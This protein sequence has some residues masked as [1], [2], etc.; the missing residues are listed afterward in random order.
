MLKAEGVSK[1]YGDHRA[2][3][4]FNVE[5]EQG[6]VFGLLGPNG[7]GKT[8]FIRILNQITAPDQGSIR[9][10]GEKLQAKHIQEIGYLPEER[11]L[12]P[13][14]KVGEQLLYLARLKG[15]SK[16]EANRKVKDWLERFELM[17]RAKKNVEELSKGLAQKVQFIASVIHEPS[18]IILDEPFTGF[19]PINTEQIK[20]E[21]LRLRKDGATV[22]FST[23]RMESVE[24]LCEKIVLINKG[25]KVLDGMLS[26]IKKQ[27]RSGNYIIRTEQA[28]G[29]ISGLNIIEH[30]QH[31]DAHQY[32]IEAN[33]LNKQSLL[34]KVLPAGLVSFE[35]EEAHLHDIFIKLARS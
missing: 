9:L 34:E 32:L 31:F 20:Q 29:T 35:E 18:L 19:D 14:M 10:N 27:Y 26:D 25:E 21:I 5:I 13:K 1:Y 3:H 7:A 23:H 11:G 22:I 17:D 33:A 12:Y 24:E 15:L 28:L 2:L 6:S 16:E 8:S 4:D 30:K